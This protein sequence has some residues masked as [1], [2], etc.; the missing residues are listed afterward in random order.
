MECHNQ[1]SVGPVQNSVNNK[2]IN[3]QNDQLNEM[4][5]IKGMSTKCEIK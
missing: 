2:N 1:T 5:L 3:P 4:L